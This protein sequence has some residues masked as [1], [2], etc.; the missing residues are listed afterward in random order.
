L[1]KLG[2]LILTCLMFGAFSFIALPKSVHAKDLSS[3][4][5]Y[6]T[7]SSAN[8][9]DGKNPLNTYGPSGKTCAST[10]QGVKGGNVNIQGG[11]VT[12]VYSSDCKTNWSLVA[13]NSSLTG[14]FPVN[15]NVTRSSDGR[16]YDTTVNIT[17]SYAPDSPMVY[18]PTVTA[19]ACGSINNWPGGCT[20][21]F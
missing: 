1:K 7:C 11:S 12:L 17:S 2:Y 9:C 20:G 4:I 19:R 8:T 3:S 5:A 21:W 10:G 6:I 16:R 15:A 18:A 14:T 13:P